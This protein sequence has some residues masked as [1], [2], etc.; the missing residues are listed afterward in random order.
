M[1]DDRSTQGTLLIRG[2]LLRSVLLLALHK[3]G[4]RV[5][6]VPELVLVMQAQGFDVPGRAGKV[7]SDALRSELRRGRVARGGRGEYRLVELPRTTHRRCVERV[8]AARRGAAPV[9]HLVA[10]SSDRE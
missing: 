9:W 1:H 10:P 7:V 5:V 8:A 3:A 4:G 2:T 6:T